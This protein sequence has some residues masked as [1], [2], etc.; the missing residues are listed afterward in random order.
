MDSS[1]EG[2]GKHHHQVSLTVLREAFRR[3]FPDSGEVIAVR[4]PGRVNLIGEHT[5]YNDGYVMPVAIDRSVYL[6]AS[7]RRD[8]NVHIYAANFGDFVSFRL[9]R[10]RCDSIYSWSNYERGI[11]QYLQ[12]SGHRLNGAD[13]LV[14]STIPVGGGLGSSAAVEMATVWAFRLL[15][16]LPISRIEAAKLCQRVENEFVGVRCGIMDQFASALGRKGKVLFLDCR[17]LEYRYIALGM[18]ELRIVICNTNLPRTLASSAYNE[19]R[20]ECQEG[21]RQFQRFLPEVRALRDVSADDF[22]KYKKRLEPKVAQRCNHVI[23]E[24]RRVLIGA[25]LLQ[26]GDVTGF[27]MLMGHS[28]SSLRDNY[29]VSCRD[30]D[31]LVEIAKSVDGVLGARMTGAG[32]GGCTVNLVRTEAVAHLKE[33]VLG[34]YPEQTGRRPEVY[35]CQ[36]EGGVR[37]L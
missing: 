30:L 7:S 21:L 12:D 13:M 14:W 11:A 25:D 18:D 2:L 16:D 27:G 6:L 35:V 32:F 33:R 20:E 24:N 17:T 26:R 4:A 15:N 31:L 10:I 5:D 34:L 37:K 29:E 8:G 22:K 28:H 1:P 36:A 19:R 3:R 9:N 23:F